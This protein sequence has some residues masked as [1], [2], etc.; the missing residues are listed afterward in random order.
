MQNGAFHPVRGARQG[1]G[2]PGIERGLCGGHIQ[3][4][5]FEE[6]LSQRVEELFILI[7]PR[8]RF[9]QVKHNV[10]AHSR[11]SNPSNAASSGKTGEPCQRSASAM[12]AGS[13]FPSG[14]DRWALRAVSKRAVPQIS[15]VGAGAS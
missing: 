12:S 10:G 13:V 14:T 7:D 9:G 15:P 1:L 11:N 4:S 5:L 3:R 8:E 2:I 6:Q